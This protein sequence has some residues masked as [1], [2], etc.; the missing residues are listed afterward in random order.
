MTIEGA[1]DSVGEED[2]SDEDVEDETYIP[3]PQASTDGRGK[4]LASGSGSEAAEIQEEEEEGEDE[5]FYVKEINPPNYIHMGTP[6]FTQP[7]NLG[8]RQKVSYKGKTK[9]V[10][11][12]RMENPRLHA[13]ETTD[14]RFHTFF[15][16]DFYKSI[17]ITKGKSVV[18]SQWI[19]WSYMKNK[20][21]L[22]FNNVVAACRAKHLRDVMAFKKNW[23]NK[24]IAQ[25]FATLYVEEHGDTS[26]IHWMMEG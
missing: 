7:Q 8:W 4:G 11:E 23:N 18:I 17:I 22:M 6:T 15:Q 13:R 24:V 2:S 3:S 12:K 21:D 16:Q 9:V 25:F 5:N 1:R 10:R 14:Y 26:K 19:D 20:H